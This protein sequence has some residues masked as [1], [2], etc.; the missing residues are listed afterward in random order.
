MH[1]TPPRRPRPRWV[2]ATLA[3]VAMAALTV[4]MIRL[5]ENACAGT[6]PYT[7]GTAVYHNDWSV[8][9][10]SMGPLSHNGLY[11][12]MSAGEYDDASLCG[13][14]LEATG[15]RGTVRAQVV[16][17]CRGC[18]YGR[19]DL[20]E[21]AFARIGDVGKGVIPVRYRL[22]RDPEPAA[23]LTVRVKPG[24]TSEWLALLVLGHGNPLARVQLRRT[25][26]AWRSMSRSLDNYWSLSGP[27][28]GPFLV[29]VTDRF[30]NTA[31]LTDVN[32]R[33][34]GTQGGNARLY[35]P[36]AKP[37]TASQ[38]AVPA[39]PKAAPSAPTIVP[40]SSPKSSHQCH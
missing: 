16:D 26:E 34:T 37:N 21:R 28:A 1:A 19:V 6:D 14:Y 24:S 15:P 8:V 30:G 38:S 36:L 29:R 9:L 12:S 3:V 39:P 4:G 11:A 18:G 31:T 7:R 20:S 32:P 27:G 2:W 22:V 5:Q 25:G 35:G 10:C 40:Q 23:R 13:S 17:R 33:Y